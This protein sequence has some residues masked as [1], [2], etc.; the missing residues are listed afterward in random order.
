MGVEHG[1]LLWVGIFL[2]AYALLAERVA[3]GPLT[4]PLVALAAGVCLHLAGAIPPTDL[5]R[6]PLLEVTLG[7]L[8]FG[9]GARFLPGRRRSLH[10][11]PARLLLVALPASLAAGAALALVLFPGMALEAAVVVGAALAATDTGLCSPALLPGREDDPLSVDLRL[12][13]GLSDGLVVAFE[14][15]VLGAPAFDG[16]PLLSWA[17]AAAVRVGLAALVGAGVAVAGAAL[18]RRA[19]RHEPLAAGA[20]QYLGAGLAI[21]SVAGATAV[22]AS[23]P[24][25]AFVAGLALARLAPRLEEGVEELGPFRGEVLFV[26]AFVT[27]GATI[28]PQILGHVTW[29]VVAYAAASLTVVR[30]A[31]V[32]LAFTGSGVPARELAYLSWFGPRGLASLLVARI[33]V[34]RSDLPGRQVALVAIVTTVAASVVLHGLTAAP[35]ARLLRRRGEAAAASVP[36]RER[37]RGA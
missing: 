26:L 16:R 34:E 3:R 19:E 9:G 2:V 31:P 1:V 21:L 29:Q 32:F 13:E 35:F 6:G 15:M 17:S 11:G 12:E 4:L 23:G 10:Q 22:H 37:S 28:V 36:L 7:L 27:L 30:A 25:A 5:A 14:A 18:L 33:L 20:R 8:L 24:T